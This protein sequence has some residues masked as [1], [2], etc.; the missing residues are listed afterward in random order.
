MRVLSECRDCFAQYLCRGGV[1]GSHQSVVHPFAF[2]PRCDKTGSPEIGEVPGNLWLRRFNHLDEVADAYLLLSHEV[3]QTK[4]R[5]IGEGAKKLRQCL[6]PF[7][8][9]S[10]SDHICLDEYEYRD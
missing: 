9:P 2:A 4:P 6:L 8:N 7:H 3:D 5:A 1:G 10:L